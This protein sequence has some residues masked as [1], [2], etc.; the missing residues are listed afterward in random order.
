[1]GDKVNVTGNF[2]NSSK[3]IMEATLIRNLSIVKRR[4]VI[5]GTITAVGGNTLTI[6]PKDHV[7]QKVTV[8]SKTSYVDRSESK[9]LFSQL[10]VG[11]QIRV[12]GMWD[13]GTNTVTEV[14]QI[15]DFSQPL[16]GSP[17]AKAH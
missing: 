8:T 2:I 1:M 11:D 15:K 12:K 7:L 9:L 14:T 16:T 5:F 3:T 10:K 6:K 17:S 4:G 13:R